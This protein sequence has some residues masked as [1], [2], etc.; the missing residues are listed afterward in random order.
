MNDELDYSDLTPMEIKMLVHQFGSI[1]KTHRLAGD[2]F[3][4]WMK[5]NSWINH[6]YTRNLIDKGYFEVVNSNNS[7][8]FQLYFSEKGWKIA[9]LLDSFSNL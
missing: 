6:P 1:S 9:N 7:S 5:V 8:D 3:I 4:C 2:M